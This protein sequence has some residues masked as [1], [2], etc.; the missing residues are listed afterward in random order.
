MCSVH[1]W[2][3]GGGAQGAGRTCPTSPR[4]K[5]MRTKELPMPPPGTLEERGPRGFRGGR[6]RPRRSQ[7]RSHC[8]PLWLGE[9]EEEPGLATAPSWKGV[10]G[11]GTALRRWE[12]GPRMGGGRRAARGSAGGERWA[13]LL[14]SPSCSAQ[15]SSSL[16]PLP[17]LSQSSCAA[18]F[19]KPPLVS[20]TEAALLLRPVALTSAEMRVFVGSYVS[21]RPH[22]HSHTHTR[23]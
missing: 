10:L 8:G 18:S 12:A 19:G 21:P 17:T 5:P 4:L 3:R 14:G 15:T 11:R 16:L 20:L 2:G 6:R 9:A 7:R 23:L 22:S 13:L 1:T